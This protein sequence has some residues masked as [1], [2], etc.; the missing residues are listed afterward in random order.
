MNKPSPLGIL[1]VNNPSPLGILQVNVRRCPDSHMMVMQAFAFLY[2]Y[3]ELRGEDQEACLNL[4]RAYHQIGMCVCVLFIASRWCVFFFHWL[5]CVFVIDY[6]VC[7]FLYKYF[8]L[9]GE[10]QEACLDLARAYHQIGTC[11]CVFC[12]LLCV[13]MCLCVCVRFIGWGV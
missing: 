8:E 12:W 5:L 13:G 11:V 6:C 1:Q 10:D 7:A 3:F 4:A 2:K 9:R